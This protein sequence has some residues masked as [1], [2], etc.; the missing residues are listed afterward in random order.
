MSSIG[1]VQCPIVVGRDDLLELADRR[2]RDVAA[3]HGHSL[4]LA[5][6]A[7]VGKTRVLRAILRKAEAAGFRVARSDLAPQDRLLPLAAILDLAR[8]M[9]GEEA[10]GSLGDELLAIQRDE[11]RI[12]ETF[13]PR[14]RTAVPEVKV[15][16]FLQIEN[17][18]DAVV[19]YELADAIPLIRGESK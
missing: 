19:R 7:G 18:L 16:R 2:I 6:E 5:G 15:A 3:R 12:K 14:F 9:Q 10:F 4:L 11:L 1:P 17:K 13:L 8:T